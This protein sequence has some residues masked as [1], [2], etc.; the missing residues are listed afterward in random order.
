MSGSSSNPTVRIERDILVSLDE[1]MDRQKDMM[2][3][4]KTGK[5]MKRK[6]TPSRRWP[7]A[8]VPYEIAPNTF[9]SCPAM[10]C[11]GEG[12]VGKD[13]QCK[14]PTNDPNNPIQTCAGTAASTTTTAAPPTSAPTNDCSDMNMYCSYWAGQGYCETSRY[15]MMYCK[16]SCRICNDKASI[17][18]SA[19][20]LLMLA[21]VAIWRIL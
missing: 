21:V 15:M 12:F 13:C 20:A 5:R 16:E 1:Y 7:S 2:E 10:N 18:E 3:E 6:A 19:S 11:P 14:C 8:I 4:E 17:L 9:R